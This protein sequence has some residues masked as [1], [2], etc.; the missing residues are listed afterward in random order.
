MRIKVEDESPEAAPE[1]ERDPVD[2]AEKRQEERSAEKIPEPEARGGGARIT[3][4]ELPRRK[5]DDETAELRRM[6]DNLTEELKK[7]ETELVAAEDRAMR[8][9]AD[10][11]NFKKRL[12]REREEESRYA[13]ASL[14]E[15]L[16]PALDNFEQAIAAAKSGEVD[17]DSLTE[18]VDM[19]HRQIMD[20]LKRRGLDRIEAVGAPFDPETMEAVRLLESG[21]HEDNEVVEEYIPGYR[22]KDRVIRH[23]KVRVA[24]NTG[25]KDGEN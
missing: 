14:V 7:R 15:A 24:K 1:D 8:A 2:E 17:V 10:A 11:E 9:V 6:V 12:Q 22:F 3:K 23:A 16:L 4:K 21:E 20:V 13:N 18:G 19:V 25:E 5:K